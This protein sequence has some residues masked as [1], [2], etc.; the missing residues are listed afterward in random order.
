M[1]TSSPSHPTRVALVDAYSMGNQLVPALQRQGAECLHVRS[2]NPDIHTVKLKFPEGF[3][4]DIRHDGDVAATASALREWGVSCVLAGGESGVELTDQ[5]SAA[6][7]T[8]GNGM[9]R[10]ASR[11]DKYEMVLALRDAGMVHAATIVSSDADE[12]IA[13]A[14]ANT[15]YPIV[16]KPVASSGRDNVVACA[17]AEEVRA[18]HRRITSTTDRVGKP[19][20]VVL[21]QEFLDGDEYFVNTV[22]RDGMHHTVEIW[23]Y[24]K[25]RI[26]GGH[27]IHDYTEP[28]A[29]DDPKAGRLETYAHQV[30]DALE[31]HNGASHAE[32]M[33]TAKGP[34]L[35]EC[36]GRAGGGVVPEILSRGLG[37]NQ[38][39][40]LA[41]S[42]ARPDEFNRLPTS[43][44]RL[45]RHTR[46]VNLINLA[47]HGIAPSHEAMAA[48]RA[49][50]S[51]AHVVLIHQEGRPLTRTVDFAT[52]PGYVFLISDDLAQLRADY[53]KLREIEEDLYTGSPDRQPAEGVSP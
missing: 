33:L 35:V 34:V 28:L 37:A 39:D 16:L 45:L 27:T 30:L 29:P 7:G 12:I 48:I 2:L 23:R 8:P 1:S 31:I 10:P 24:H 38:I 36:A 4:A 47:D 9:T 18:S 22:S 41:L 51:C 17:S 14:E 52:Q 11:R 43:V 49:L 3:I 15:G 20:T 50:P 42:A 32:I 19:N 21:A 25:R 46:F 5:L 6:L 40:L 26:A 53:R 44:F 13:W